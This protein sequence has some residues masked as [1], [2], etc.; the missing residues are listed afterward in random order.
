MKYESEKNGISLK[1][2]LKLLINKSLGSAAK[3]LR[4]DNLLHSTFIIHSAGERIFKMMNIWPSY[5]QNI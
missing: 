1:Y 2:V 4:N 5:R 3:H